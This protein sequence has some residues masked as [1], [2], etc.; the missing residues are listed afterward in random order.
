MA[1]TVNR[2][3]SSPRLVNERLKRLQH[4][5]ISICGERPHCVQCTCSADDDAKANQNVVLYDDVV[6]GPWLLSGVAV[7]LVMA[8][9]TVN[10]RYG[11]EAAKR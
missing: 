1:A 7:E 5:L 10:P 11:G 6:L 8:V 9:R 4:P 2:H 3:V